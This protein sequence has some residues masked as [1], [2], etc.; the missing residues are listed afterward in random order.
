MQYQA[1]LPCYAQAHVANRTSSAARSNSSS[2]STS[3]SSSV[4]K[5]QEVFYALGA[6][7]AQQTSKFKD[8][9][10]AEEREVVVQ[11][12]T[13]GWLD[14]PLV[15]D[16]ESLAVQVNAML[17]ERMTAESDK[18]AAEG[19]KFL[20]EAAKE[21]ALAEAAKEVYKPIAN[22]LLMHAAACM[23]THCA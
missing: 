12:M 16:P 8:L 20:A 18:L 10:T 15:I 14:K 5:D 1:V 3:M 7:L 22:T 19:P 2:S 13:D 23:G 17:E 9:L 4:P 11:G 6:A 21:I